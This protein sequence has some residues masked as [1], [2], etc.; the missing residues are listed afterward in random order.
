ML[1]VL[2]GL[3]SVFVLQV[4]E[5]MGWISLAVAA[6]HSPPVESWP[7]F[8]TMSDIETPLDPDDV[9]SSLQVT[10]ELDTR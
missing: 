1:L 2:L 6:T 5:G 3:T 4:A 9:K 7:A 10:V 8:L